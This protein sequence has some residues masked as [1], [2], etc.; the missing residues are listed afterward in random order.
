MKNLDV[1]KHV[2]EEDLPH[3]GVHWVR[4]ELVVEVGFTEWTKHGKLRH[5]RYIGLREDKEPEDVMRERPKE[6]SP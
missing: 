2:S 1:L 6:V 5:P 4:P 3:K